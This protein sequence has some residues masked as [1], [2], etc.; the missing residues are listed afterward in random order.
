MNKGKLRSSFAIEI[1]N[2]LPSTTS[3][4]LDYIRKVL[5]QD[6]LLYI[7]SQ[8]IKAHFLNEWLVYSPIN[9]IV[10]NDVY[11]IRQDIDENHSKIGFIE[12]VFAKN[13][14]S[15]FI[16]SYN[17]FLEYSN[18]FK[19]LCVAKRNYALIFEG[20][21]AIEEIDRTLFKSISTDSAI[22]FYITDNPNVFI[23]YLENS[24]SSLC[25]YVNNFFIKKPTYKSMLETAN[26]FYFDD[27]EGQRN[28][29]KK[30]ISQFGIVDDELSQF[31]IQRNAFHYLLFEDICNFNEHNKDILKDEAIISKKIQCLIKILELSNG[32]TIFIY[33]DNDFDECI[34]YELIMLISEPVYKDNRKNECLVRDRRTKI[35]Q[36][37]KKGHASNLRFRISDRVLKNSTTYL[38]I[39]SIRDIQMNR[40]M[41]RNIV[42]F[43]FHLFTTQDF[44]IFILPESMKVTLKNMTVDD[45][46]IGKLYL[47]YLKKCQ[48]NYYVSTDGSAKPYKFE[49]F[50][51][52]VDHVKDCTKGKDFILSVDK[53]DSRMFVVAKCSIGK[54]ATCFNLFNIIKEPI[55]IPR[56]SIARQPVVL[57]CDSIEFCTITSLKSLC[58]SKI[59]RNNGYFVL[60]EKRSI[61]YSFSSERNLM[62][63][64]ES[65]DIEDF[66]LFSYKKVMSKG[67]I[68]KTKNFSKKKGFNGKFLK[69]SETE[70]ENKIIKE[71]IA[72]VKQQEVPKEHILISFCLRNRLKV[73]V[74]EHSNEIASKILDSTDILEK[75]EFF[76]MLEWKR[77]AI[78]YFNDHEERFDLR[79][80]IPCFQD[81][82][83]DSIYSFVY[84]VKD[85]KA[86]TLE[87]DNK[88]EQLGIILRN[89]WTNILLKVF[90]NYPSKVVCTDLVRIAS[91]ISLKDVL[92]RFHK[93]DFSSFYALSCLISRKGRFLL[94]KITNSD[95]EYISSQYIPKYCECLDRTLNTRFNPI[96]FR[97]NVDIKNNIPDNNK[98][99][100]RT[101]ILTP[102]S[103]IFN[104]ESISE[105]NRVLRNFDPDKFCRVTIREENGKD[106]FMSD[107]TKNT[108]DVYDYFRK[109]MLNGLVIGS[110]K[111]FFLVMTASQ[112][113]IH[114]SWFVTPYEHD[115]TIIGADYIKSWIGNFHKIKN[116][117]KYAIRIGLALSTTTPTYQFNDFIEIDDIQKNSY[118]FTDGIGLITKKQAKCI[119]AI[120]GLNF[121][122]SAFQIRFGGYKG[123]VTV[124]PWMDD[125]KSFEEWLAE[126]SSI[127]QGYGKYS[128]INNMLL[129]NSTS[130][131]SIVFNNTT[132][133]SI[134]CIAASFK[135]LGFPDLILRK[136]MN[137]F[138][139]SHRILEIIAASKSSS[140]Y[141][142][143][144]IILMLE[145]L[146]VSTHVF[147][148]LQDKYI[149]NMLLKLSQD[150]ISFIKKCTGLM[151]NISTDLPFYRKL[152]SQALAKVFEELNTKSKIFVGQGRGAIGV[153]DELGIL[154]EDQIF[155]M[156]RKDDD[157]NMDNLN[158][159]G[160]YIVPNCHCIIAKNPVMHPGDIR[161][162]RCVD[163]PQLHYLKDVIVFSKKG[164]RPVFNQCSGSDLDG[165][166]FL[167]SWCKALMPR[168]TFKPYNYIDTCALVKDKVLLTDIVNFYIRHMK[169]Y[170]LGQIAHSHLAI[171]DK[172]TAF[173]EKSL[174]LSD[175]F[176][177][178]IDY[179]K[180]GR[181]VSIPEDIIPTEYPD[182]MERSPS[183]LSVKAIG[184]LYRRS[185]LD[186]SGISFCE[187]HNCTVKE[188]QEQPK[189]KSFILLGA[190]VKT[191][192]IS[193]NAPLSEE[194]LSI[195][196]NYVSDIRLLMDKT[197]AKTEEDLF[198]HNF[199]NDL[200]TGLE[201]RNIISKYTEILKTKEALKM[202]KVCG[203]KNF[204]GILT[205]CGDSYKLKNMIKRGIIKNGTSN[206]IFN[207]KIHLS[208]YEEIS[209][210]KNNTVIES[211]QIDEFYENR[212]DR[213]GIV[214]YCDRK[215][216][217]SFIESLDFKRKDMFKD[218]FNLII[219]SGLFKLD[220][221]DE[222][223]DLL[224]RFNKA[225]KE[226]TIE[227]LLQVAMPGSDNM[228][229][230]ILCLLPLDFSLV[231]KN[232][233]FR[234]K[235]FLKFNEKYKISKICKR[236]CLIISGMLDENDDI[237][238][239]KENEAI[240]PHLK[241]KGVCSVE[242][243]K[244]TMRDFLINILYSNEN[245]MFLKKL[246]D[247]QE[248][249][250]D[251]K[252]K[253]WQDSEEE[254]D[255]EIS[256]RLS[257]PRNYLEVF[258]DGEEPQRKKLKEHTPGIASL[259]LYEI[260]FYPGKFIFAQVPEIYLND[261]FSVRNIETM[262][263]S[264]SKSSLEK[265][266]F[267]FDNIHDA[268]S[269]EKRAEFLS[270]IKKMNE[271]GIREVLSFIYKKIRFDI[272]I[273]D[274]KLLRITKD[275]KIIGKGFIVNV[276]QR[277]DLQVELFRKEI[278]YDGTVN[279]LAENEMFMTENLFIA[280]N[281]TYK[282][283]F[284]LAKYPCSKVKLERSTVFSN[285][286]GFIIAYK[287]L[288]AGDD[289]LVFKADKSC[290]Y[291]SNEI[292]ISTVEGFSFDK[293]FEKLWR[294]YTTIL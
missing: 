19:N 56:L 100:I 236:F 258:V 85:M 283:T 232:M 26:F 54:I 282:L 68:L 91:I 184:H 125:P 103:V 188:I 114:S 144:Q 182:F 120:L 51:T 4:S 221:I 11:N 168:V 78:D 198:Y 18:Y 201:L 277:N 285:E 172:F 206:F 175:I 106:R 244:D 76:S 257:V 179:V 150:F 151:M 281:N 20:I 17:E 117:G 66:I 40:E 55:L 1:F 289:I 177:K 166:I 228:L 187:C 123:I 241:N 279:F 287:T 223:I 194:Y 118:C 42:L 165:D 74:T 119:S 124:H 135:Q 203:C 213:E 252:Q 291:T 249:S 259:A 294:V 254:R 284:D 90:S 8:N 126:N 174:K 134:D 211:E 229:F 67:E 22:K 255:L 93:S 288:F 60:L 9:I 247:M 79:I 149:Q 159:Y 235:G 292:C 207:S 148:T 48:I 272:E 10:T 133:N 94:S 105:S 44:K 163:I 110:R 250:E 27:S 161:T 82:P 88:S 214:I 98:V 23:S 36:M 142:N 197:Q 157:E 72:L 70:G 200:N 3:V 154:E 264:K 251:I 180:T 99:M 39:H 121:I 209:S 41:S 139:S 145:G 109:V 266:V 43:N 130:F 50:S 87:S 92:E 140:F 248:R 261:R 132:I 238:F 186:L 219:L 104:Y 28:I 173:N 231:K 5:K 53:V 129:H 240:V 217:E 170:Q 101:V 263:S 202:S 273:L 208:N 29:L 171:S 234:E 112:L 267:N 212:F 21:K 162:V 37:M 224:I 160:S 262:L 122:P 265:I 178:N 128:D 167:I 16:I 227:E 52:N 158:D 153:L 59:V 220:Q 45:S 137:K 185:T 61:F 34:L 86:E 65:S 81:L 233:L 181:I 275:K 97:L 14:R 189:W 225:M 95:L 218:M 280:E 260:Y 108:D 205:L 199:E 191:R 83:A 246:A 33:F 164:N 192:E 146:G 271:D 15:I 32:S 276:S 12:D 274:G 138:D 57:F 116:I 84:S 71:Y 96:N 58:N 286:D 63:E 237:E 268:L 111:Y 243:Y 176:N 242:Y 239:I 30:G 216:Y 222:I 62:F 31:L 245:L 131:D 102:L 204:N 73:Y 230:K 226:S 193:S 269:P 143:R 2:K 46:N 270:S 141:L 75:C 38:N 7:P 290:C 35:Y 49:V 13:E 64:I 69:S 147:I 256:R 215:K 47:H 127:I 80:S 113:K 107:L 183:Y 278:V 6:H 210:Q 24:N 190:G 195:Y 155:C 115:G 136:S 156:F 253:I 196:E 152:Q 293:I 25:C 77:Q 89:C 169:F